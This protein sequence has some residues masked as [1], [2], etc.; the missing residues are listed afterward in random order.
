MTN[1]LI[2]VWNCSKQEGVFWS[3]AALLVAS[4]LRRTLVRSIFY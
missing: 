2:A 3:Q 1:G 4:S